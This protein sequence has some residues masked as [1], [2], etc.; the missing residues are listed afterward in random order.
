MFERF[1][2]LGKKNLDL[3]STDQ[4]PIQVDVVAEPKDDSYL[5]RERI[6]NLFEVSRLMR[7]EGDSESLAVGRLALQNIAEISTKHGILL[8]AYEDI[9]HIHHQSTLENSAG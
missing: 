4:L 2:N 5:A 6:A 9:Y 1:R 7:I 8:W 3:P